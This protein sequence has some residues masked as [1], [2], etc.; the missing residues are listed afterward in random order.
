MLSVDGCP[1]LFEHFVG[2]TQPSDSPP[3]CMLDF[4][5]MAFSNRPT[6]VCCPGVERALISRIHILNKYERAVQRNARAIG[7]LADTNGESSRQSLTELHRWLAYTVEARHS[8]YAEQIL[9]PKP[10]QGRTGAITF[11]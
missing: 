1:S 4:W 6:A 8:M 10:H 3:T 5:L 11:R 7:G 9:P 2:T